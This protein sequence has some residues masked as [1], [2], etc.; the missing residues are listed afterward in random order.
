MIDLSVALQSASILLREGVEAMLVIAALAAFLRRSGAT[1]ELRAI[2]LGAVTAILASVLAAVVF[3]VFLGGAHD[4][5]LEAA[6]MLLAAALMLYMSGWLFLRQNPRA[7]NATLHRSAERAMSSGTSLSLASIAFLAV[8]REGGETVLFL[9][10]LARSSGGWNASLNVGLLGAFVGLLALYAAM[11]WLAFRL[12]LRPVFLLTSGF[13]FLMGLRFIGGAVQE[14]QE[15]A[16]ISYD[17]LAAPDW[18][19]GLGLN[20][21]WEAVV[22]QLAVAVFVAASTLVMYARRPAVMLAA[23]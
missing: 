21:T 13:L 18:L 4:D 9:H 2:Y 6:V 5:R 3:D 7:W 8:F 19:I 23:E 1:A 14:L 17:A 22:A 16:I 12:P 10:A 15:Q 20:P 11:Q